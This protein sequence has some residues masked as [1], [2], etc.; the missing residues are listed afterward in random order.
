LF[1]FCSYLKMRDAPSLLSQDAPAIGLADM[2][3]RAALPRRSRPLSVLLLIK[4][5]GDMTFEDLLRRLR[6]NRCQAAN[7][8]PVYVVAGHHRTA[9]GGPDPDWSIELVPPRNMGGPASR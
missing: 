5:Q 4:R 8:A 6:C 7:P 2:R 1:F 3:D 9:C